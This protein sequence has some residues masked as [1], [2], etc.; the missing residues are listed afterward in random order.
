VPAPSNVRRHF[1]SWDRPLLPQAVNW[2]AE[3]WSGKGPLDLS[4][5]LVVVPTRQAGRRLREALAAHAAL[6]GTAVFPPRVMLPEV[7]VA[8]AL[9][10][11]LPSPLESLLAWT[12]VFRSVSLDEYR[13]VF[14]VDPPDRSF[15]WALRL[16]S[17]FNRLQ[18]TLT[19]ASL[20]LDEVGERAGVDFSEEQRW[21]EIAR[22]AERHRA[23]LLAAGLPA[24]SGVR[25]EPGIPL[26]VPNGIQRVV[27]LAAPDPLA[28]A[29]EVLAAYAGRIPI[30]VVIFAPETESTAFDDWGRPRD[31]VWAS[32]ELVLPNFEQ[33]VHLCAHPTAQASRIAET[34][35]QYAE[36]ASS[37]GIG[38][39]DAEVLPVLESALEHAHLAAFN[40]EGMPRKG[41]GLYQLLTALAAFARD[42]SFSVVETLA[43][44]PDIADFLRAQIGEA[45]SSAGFL[46]EL[47]SLHRRHLSPDLTEARRH[48]PQNQ[49]LSLLVE[50]RAL[51]TDGEFPHSAAAA[52][53]IIFGQRR[54]ILSNPRDARAAEAAETWTATLR[55]I[56]A[57]SEKFTRIPQAD[58]WELALRIYGEQVRYDDKPAD[59]LELQGWLELLWE[60]APH[61]MVAGLNDGRVPDAIVGD[62]FLPESLRVRLGLKTNAARFARDA[63]LLQAMAA[64]RAQE[65][66]LELLVGKNSSA[67]EP[68][69]PSRLLLQCLDQ[70]LPGRVRYLFGAVEAPDAAPGWHRAWQ[71]R[72]PVVPAPPRLAATGFRAW[73][74]CPFRFYLARVL[75]ME[76]VDAA[77]TELDVFDFGTLC[78]AA[79]EAMGLEMSLRNCTDEK[80]LRQFLL[81]QLERQSARR[82]GR[83]LTLPLVIQLE[84][85]RQRLSRAAETQALSR[86]EGWVIESVERTF[87]VPV[88]DMTITGKIDRIDRHEG[89]GEVRVLDYK[90]SDRPVNPWE[91]HLR[92]V[93]RNEL[94]ATFARV[95]YQAKEYVW[96]DLQ[97]PLYLRAV[98]G[99][100]G[101]AGSTALRI[102]GGYFNLPKAASETGIRPW[103]DYP[104]ELDEAAWRC[105]E[106]VSA[107]ILAGDF[108]PANENIRPERDEFASLFHQGVAAS[109]SWKGS[110]A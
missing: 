108:W 48:A 79:L 67:G 100:E 1:L 93:R 41:D 89:S 80:I 97:L 8:S 102:H 57:A 82:F 20:G 32:R 17:E 110:V 99:W 91:A 104:P 58:G 88:G 30:E 6:Q 96:T 72:P 66:R 37:I 22:L 15:S 12:E 78:H 39:A 10:P 52:L 53:G 34:V 2:L 90:T 24:P 105:A 106:G 21:R 87:E 75:R 14:P 18:H 28:P 7:L 46:R 45:F 60:D 49:A 103:G 98:R 29:L 77:K 4:T 84:S 33:R 109:V 83:N 27:L 3:S 63:Y 71:L 25:R 70:Q 13:H 51:L 42:D 47:D 36:P 85:A 44:C 9:P 55:E 68:L 62:P 31:D 107:A 73:L 92:G 81:E 54:F 16:A 86:A 101:A 43:R 69:R 40:P 26:E 38:I 64:S 50:L 35:K 95:M 74:E 94:A 61:L 76:A 65:G 56:A 11:G 59:A 19:E 23:T 5:T